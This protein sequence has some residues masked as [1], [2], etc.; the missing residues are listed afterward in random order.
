MVKRLPRG[1]V[2]ARHSLPRPPPPAGIT[3]PSWLREPFSL[4]RVA[5]MAG[6]SV[7]CN[8]PSRHPFSGNSFATGMRPSQAPCF[9]PAHDHPGPAAWLR[10]R[11]GGGR[12]AVKPLWVAAAADQRRR[13]LL[14]AG[15]MPDTAGFVAPPPPRRAAGAARARHD[16]S[17]PPSRRFAA[18]AGGPCCPSSSTPLAADGGS[19]TSRAGPKRVPLAAGRG[20]VAGRQC[21][22]AADF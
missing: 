1:A 21:D 19:A 22:R 18:P 2:G 5:T 17:R 13:P 4:S 15:G 8:R 6:S 3:R 20:R 7:F 16:F 10:C 9:G 12:E 11:G 14:W